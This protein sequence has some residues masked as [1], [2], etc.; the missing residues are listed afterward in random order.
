[1]KDNKVVVVNEK[2]GAVFPTE[3]KSSVSVTSG[4]SG[5]QS[6]ATRVL[7]VLGCSLSKLFS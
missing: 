4:S 2:K 7:L 3:F 6:Y 1:M 5:K